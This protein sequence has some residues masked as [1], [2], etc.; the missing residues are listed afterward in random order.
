MVVVKGGYKEPESFLGKHLPK[1]S[2]G[3]PLYTIGTGG[4]R[5]KTIS[6]EKNGDSFS[7]FHFEY[8]E[9]PMK[10]GGP[11]GGDFI[12]KNLEA[13]GGVEGDGLYVKVCRCS[14]AGTVGAN[15]CAELKAVLKIRIAFLA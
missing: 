13:I 4:I 12:L 6:D 7:G 8:E 9:V 11:L 2:E 14:T 3:K 15:F 1:D 10:K 5:I